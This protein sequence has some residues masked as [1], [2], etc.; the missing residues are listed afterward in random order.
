MAR[1]LVVDDQAEN[2]DLLAYLLGYFGHDVST[3][4]DGAAGMRAALA[5]RPDLIIMDI[6]MPGVDGYTAAR[7]MRSEQALADVPLVAVSATGTA[8]L[9]RARAAGFDAFYPIPIDPRKFM[10]QIE[11][12]ISP[13]PAKSRGRSGP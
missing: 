1:I 6:A 11:P 8:T 4:P 2:R 5:G 13:D 7:L 9:K 12:F 3:A 10:I